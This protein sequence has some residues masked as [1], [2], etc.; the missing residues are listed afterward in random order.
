MT[1]DI[2]RPIETIASLE[3]APS[4]V[5]GTL[6]T[7][8]SLDV[9][10]PV[11]IASWG[12]QALGTLRGVEARASRSSSLFRIGNDAEVV[13]HT[14]LSGLQHVSTGP[15]DRFTREGAMGSS[16]KFGRGTY[17]GAGSLSGET[18][19]LLNKAGNTQH[20][21]DASGTFLLVDRRKVRE[22]AVVLGRGLGQTE[23]PI[24]STIQNAPLID[25]ASQYSVDNTQISGVVVFMNEA[26]SA[27]EIV[28]SPDATPYAYISSRTE[29]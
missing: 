21:V 16:G 14:S 11:E 26:R 3:R 17:F 29:L 1:T 28:I 10:P 27:A 22:V 24:K 15:I 6:V 12:L 13:T 8:R 18:V 19:D 2:Y 20:V 7:R 23:S 4:R 5:L 25:L 9:A